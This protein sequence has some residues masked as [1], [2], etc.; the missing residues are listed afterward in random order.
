M[1]PKKVPCIS[2]CCE[3]ALPL[4]CLRR[5]SLSTSTTFH[6]EPETPLLSCW[7]EVP[8]SRMYVPDQTSCH[9]LWSK[10][11]PSRHRPP[12]RLPSIRSHGTHTIFPILHPPT[13]IDLKMPPPFCC[14]SWPVREPPSRIKPWSQKA[15]RFPDPAQGSY[16]QPN[17][18]ERQKLAG[19]PD[20]GQTESDPGPLCLQGLKP[21]MLE[22]RVGTMPNH[23]CT[24]ASV[25]MMPASIAGHCSTGAGVENVGG[26]SLGSDG[27]P[28]VVTLVGSHMVDS[29]SSQEPET[30]KT[31]QDRSR[32]G[33]SA[34]KGTVWDRSRLTGKPKASC[35]ITC[36][37]D[38]LC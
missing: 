26:S 38:I 28:T 13:S 6:T 7:V 4:N 25:D 16:R 23:N 35:G 18:A 19:V 24:I 1:P 30:P 20:H 9:V 37:E 33:Q 17:T 27:M 10:P 22:D 5:P 31:E 8:L 34:G 12:K 3:L 2:T 21:E 29:E 14:V 15:E 11:H 36:L 32:A